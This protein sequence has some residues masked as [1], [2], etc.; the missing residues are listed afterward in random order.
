MKR[1]GDLGE[2]AGEGSCVVDEG[3]DVLAGEIGGGGSADGDC[4][5]KGG[6]SK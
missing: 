4:D 1:S 6:R 3:G 2:G 5:W